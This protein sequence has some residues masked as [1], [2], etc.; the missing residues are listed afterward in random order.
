L[1]DTR[2]YSLRLVAM[3]CAARRRKTD[4]DDHDEQI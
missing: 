4:V 2:T 3:S 1:A